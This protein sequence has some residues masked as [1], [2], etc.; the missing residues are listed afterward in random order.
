MKRFYLLYYHSFSK[1]QSVWRG[2]CTVSFRAWS[3]ITHGN[4]FTVNFRFFHL[5]LRLIQYLAISF[6]FF[7]SSYG[8]LVNLMLL[9][10]GQIELFHRRHGHKT[11]ADA[12]ISWI[13]NRF[14]SELGSWSGEQ[15]KKSSSLSWEPAAFPTWGGV[16][17]VV[18]DG[19]RTS[20]WNPACKSS[21]H[22]EV[23]TFCW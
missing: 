20:A 21:A 3:C 19:L 8:L 11:N 1:L 22:I 6:Q 16:G 13:C 14:C 7:P 17:S 18:S 2:L 10:V 12:L 15:M 5:F 9:R 23:P 4:A